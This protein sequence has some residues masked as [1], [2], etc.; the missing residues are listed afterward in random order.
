MCYLVLESQ[1]LRLLSAYT[2]VKRTIGC[3]LSRGFCCMGYG[4]PVG[5]FPL[6]YRFT[7]VERGSS[8]L[9]VP[10]KRTLI[11]EGIGHPIENA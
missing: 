9:Y 11:N 10:G 7:A 5:N 1:V 3:C 8:G 2:G 4:I 6:S